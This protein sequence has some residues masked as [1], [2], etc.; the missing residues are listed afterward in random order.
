MSD[1]V[2]FDVASG[3]ASVEINGI[4]FKPLG[5][6]DIGELEALFK[7]RVL[8]DAAKAIADTPGLSEQAAQAIMTAALK[9]RTMI[10]AVSIDGMNL[11]NS[12]ESSLY[13]M[14]MSARRHKP[15][16]T[17][18]QVAEAFGNYQKVEDA[19]EQ[20]L[21]ISGL[22]GDGS[23]GNGEVDAKKNHSTSEPSTD[24]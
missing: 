11:M 4:T 19:V 2:S 14:W 10:S 12:T 15:N 23:E 13:M 18:D 21:V 8:S 1:P 20:V 6:A 3:A 7:Q 5:P 9:A 24:S 17:L 16:I 22:K